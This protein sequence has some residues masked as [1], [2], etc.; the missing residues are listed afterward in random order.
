MFVRAHSSSHRA[1]RALL[2][3]GL[4]TSFAACAWTALGAGPAGSPDVKGLRP[5]GAQ[6]GTEVE[7]IVSGE[8]LM[9]PQELLFYKPGIS[10]KELAADGDG[11][12]KVKV[13]LAIAADCAPGEYPVR[14]RTAFGVSD[15]HTFHVGTLPNVAEVE[16]NDE[17]EKPQKIPLDVTV[18]GVVKNED[19]DYYEVDLKK[20]QRITA[21]AEALRLGTTLLDPFVA[22]LDARRF[23]LDAND[24]NALLL[25]DAV[26]SA[27]AP[28]DG[29]YI[30][31]IRE[32][33]YGGADNAKYRLHIG[34]F[35][36]PRAVFPPGGPAGQTLQVRYLGDV[37]GPIPAEIALPAAGVPV[38]ALAA[39]DGKMAPSPNLM[40]SSAFANAL[41]AEP[42]DSRE[43]ATKS[44][45]APIALNGIIE[46]AG[47]TDWFSFAAK[48]DQ[49]F[50]IEV[51]ARRLRTPLDPVLTLYGPDGKKISENDDGDT[52]DSAVDFTC[53]ADGD[54]F[55]SVRDHLKQ[56]GDSF[57]YR[58]EIAPEDPEL[59]F[60]V[61]IFKK[62][63]QDYQAAA[64]PR[65]G[66]FAMMV[67]ARKENVDG[68]IALA[69]ED[70]PPGVKVD[71]PRLTGGMTQVPVLFEAAGD[72]ASA[73]RLVRVTGSNSGERKIA[74]TFDQTVELVRGNPNQAVYYKTKVDRLP[75]VITEPAPFRIDLVQPKAPIVRNGSLRLRLNVQRNEGFK[76]PVT[77]KFLYLPNGVSAAPD[78]KIAADAASADYLLTAAGDAETRTWK[79][80]V[81]ASAKLG[82][83]DVWTSTQF[84]DLEV[85]PPFLQ[86]KMP[87]TAVVRGE[88][89]EVVC[90]LE[91]IRPFEGEAKLQLYGLPPKTSA[92]PVKITKD[93]K[94]AVFTV[95]TEADSPQGQ[96]KTLFCNA[97]LAVNGE[98]MAMGISPTATLR[99]DPPPPKKEETA[100][101]EPAPAQAAAPAAPAEKRLSRLEQLRLQQKQ[102][103]GGG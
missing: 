55:V 45:A 12:T 58:V 86:G 99:I 75:V 81:I 87:M 18:E 72:A 67:A 15:L 63:T 46:K 84:V 73:G 51:F 50:K 44:A 54:Y 21:E 10:V 85:A 47:D 70:L 36:R 88:K 8:R 6:R 74:G 22:I 103:G 92:E 59:A 4:V 30:V 29:R 62:D 28:E 16:P 1:L 7:L 77:A 48:K 68:E 102:K 97:E 2:Q 65:G 38:S 61:P 52:P 71:A 33:A 98:A 93:T 79:V 101:V 80:V 5:E 19:V 91:V 96:H 56:G 32:S 17:F 24:D 13:R 53:G 40:R 43:Q 31:Q 42:N 3:R 11:G 9:Q 69:V 57:A 66:R 78:L 14:L 25:Q 34:T 64:V 20:G 76:E 41:E 26:A 94:E 49:K 82:G 39:Q 89:A 100:K 23:E 27:I 60:N 90:N 83:G 95:V 37:A 35:P